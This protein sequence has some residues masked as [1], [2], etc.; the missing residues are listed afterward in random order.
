[1]GVLAA[2]C[3]KCGRWARKLIS[4]PARIIINESESLP[5]GSGS[6]GKFIPS[7]KGRRPIFVPSFG[8]MEREEID[9]V[10]EVAQGQEDERLQKNEKSIQK[11]SLEN[12]VE[13]A[14]RAPSGERAKTARELI[15]G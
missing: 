9:Y 8:S 11:E 12:V 4:A 1:M 6:R 2:V 7:E 13:A 5:Y 10:V 15:G 3:T 14:R